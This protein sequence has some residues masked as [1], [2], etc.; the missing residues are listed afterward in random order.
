MIAGSVGLL[1]VSKITQCTAFDSDVFL[2]DGIH[3]KEVFPQEGR[4]GVLPAVGLVSAGKH[5]VV[6]SLQISK[7]QSKT[8]LSRLSETTNGLRRPT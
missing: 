2:V 8:T 6:S 7:A 5:I 3:D 1:L 4:G